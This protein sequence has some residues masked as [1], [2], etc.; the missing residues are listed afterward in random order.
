MGRKHLHLLVRQAGSAD[1]AINTMS[2]DLI[3]GFVD[4]AFRIQR[5]EQHP[6]VALGKAM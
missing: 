2:P 6:Q 1:H 5:K 3:Q 4:V